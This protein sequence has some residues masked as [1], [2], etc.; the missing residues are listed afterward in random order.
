MGILNYL[1]SE[2]FFGAAFKEMLSSLECKI[3]SFLK[4]LEIAEE[5]VI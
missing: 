3:C 4:C 2:M 5:I 1:R